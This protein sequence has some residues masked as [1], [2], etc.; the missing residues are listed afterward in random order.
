MVDIVN[1]TGI[2]GQ[3]LGAG[4]TNLFG[5]IE[6]TII[7]IVLFLLV[8]AFMFGIPLEYLAVIIL[9]LCLATAIYLTSFWV[10]IFI[11]IIYVTM[12]IAKN[13]LFR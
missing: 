10:A 1:A 9:P 13:W 5:S 7:T 4:T 3:I 12:I 2:I 11:I 8:I 6:L